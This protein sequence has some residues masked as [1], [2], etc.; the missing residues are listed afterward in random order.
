[1]TYAIKARLFKGKRTYDEHGAMTSESQTIDMPMY[2][3]LEWNNYIKNIKNLGYTQLSII[4]ISEVT[5][6]D[7]VASYKE[8]DE[9]PDNILQELKDAFITKNEK[10]L[11]AEQKKIAELEAKLDALLNAK[12]PNPTMKPKTGGDGNGDVKN[13]KEIDEAKAEYLK[14]VG[15]KAH[16]LL[17]IAKMNKEI[18]EAKNK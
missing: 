13:S 11:T 8:I 18:L 7:R 15:K 4:T 9:A 10:P 17:S 2:G 3:S 16:H 1:M 5:Y 12:K 6:K 14:V